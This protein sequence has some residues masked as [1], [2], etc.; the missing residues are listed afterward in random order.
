MFLQ[1][2][3]ILS[4]FDSNPLIC[5]LTLFRSKNSPNIER[6]KIE[7]L[8]WHIWIAQ[9]LTFFP[10]TPYLLWFE[11]SSG[12]NGWS[13]LDQK[14][15]LWVR[16]FF[17]KMLLFARVLTLVRIPAILHH[18]WARKG[19]KTSQKGSWYANLWKL[20]TQQPQMLLWWNLPRL[21][22][23]MWM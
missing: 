21:C 17:Q 9:W 23:F 2:Y 16:L 14:C 20:L 6:K 5:D 22:I 12:G 7:P 19:P 8:F 1:I 13:K 4:N 3:K 15:K 11:P 18:I 10:T